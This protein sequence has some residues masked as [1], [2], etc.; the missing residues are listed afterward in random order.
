MAHRQVHLAVGRTNTR[1]HR[2]DPID[3]TAGALTDQVID[4]LPGDPWCDGEMAPDGEFLFVAR[5]PGVHSHAI[6]VATGKALPR[7]PLGGGRWDD[8]AYHPMNGG[9]ISTESDNGDLPLID[10]SR[11]PMKTVL[12]KGVCP[13]SEAS[14]R[15]RLTRVV[16]SRLARP[17]TSGSS[18]S[19]STCRRCPARRSKRSVRGPVL[20]QDG[21]AYLE[22]V[23]DQFLAAGTSRPITVR[24]TAPGRPGTSVPPV[25]PRRPQ[26][27]A[28]AH[29]G[30]RRT[31]PPIATGTQTDAYPKEKHKGV[32]S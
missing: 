25:T 14:S 22:P 8:F 7:D 32:N 21:K 24:I 17:R 18:A 10:P 13:P 9:L 11:Q 28:A 20:N 26:G 19:P 5:A 12:E 1:I 30:Q 29:P 3:V 15:D 16:L 6:D 23:A 27:H 4:G 2:F 31:E